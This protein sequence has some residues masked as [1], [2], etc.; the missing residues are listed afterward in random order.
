MPTGKS[1]ALLTDIGTEELAYVEVISSMIYQLT[2][3]ASPKELEAAGFGTKAIL[4]M[5]M[6][7]SHLIQEVYHLLLHISM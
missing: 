3:N 5:D 4:K 1:R 2:E 6:V 7:Y